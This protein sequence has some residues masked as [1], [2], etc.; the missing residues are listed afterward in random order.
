MWPGQRWGKRGVTK[1]V[2]KFR[3]ENP[4]LRTMSQYG[5]TQFVIKVY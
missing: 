3:D 5:D 1:A 2:D 4:Q